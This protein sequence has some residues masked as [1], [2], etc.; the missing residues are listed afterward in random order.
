MLSVNLAVKLGIKQAALSN[1]VPVQ[2]VIC[3]AN[4]VA[5]RAVGCTVPS[6]PSSAL[7]C[8][9]CDA[10]DGVDVSGGKMV[11]EYSPEQPA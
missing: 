7:V 4:T 10:A 2:S 11:S 6:K 1:V 3:P 9:V 5:P 8:H